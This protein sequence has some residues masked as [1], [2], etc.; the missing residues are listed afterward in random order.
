LLVQLGNIAQRTNGMLTVDPSNGHILNNTEAQSLW[1][2][3]YEPG[4]EPVI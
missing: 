4:W 3:A 2:R 1:K